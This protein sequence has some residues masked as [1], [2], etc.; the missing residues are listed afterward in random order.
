[1]TN[2]RLSVLIRLI[3]SSL[4]IFSFVPVFAQIKILGPKGIESHQGATLITEA[5][6]GE[7][8]TRSIL[9]RLSPFSP[10]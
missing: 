2:S 1:M 5:R 4:P 9:K 10:F 7:G 8:K 6:A 3:R